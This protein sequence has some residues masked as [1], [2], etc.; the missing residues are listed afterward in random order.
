MS[1]DNS[2]WGSICSQLERATPSNMYQ[3]YFAR[4]ATISSRL[5]FGSV[6][7]TQ[8]VSVPS[9]IVTTANGSESK[10]EESIPTDRPTSVIVVR[11][12]SAIVAFRLLI[13]SML[14][15]S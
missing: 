5:G 15:S 11:A 10:G 6:L 12:E 8:W 13:A 2:T 9:T 7:R 4:S 3:V 1:V 14:S